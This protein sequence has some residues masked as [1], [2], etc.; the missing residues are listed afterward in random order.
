MKKT[1]VSLLTALLLLVCMVFTMSAC[2]GTGGNGGE[3]TGGGGAS[4]EIKEGQTYYDAGT[5]VVFLTDGRTSSLNA[6]GVI[7]SALESM[8]ADGFKPAI[9]SASNAATSY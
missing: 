4:V 3:G 7:M 2:A 1:Y 5:K 6:S 8:A 9:G